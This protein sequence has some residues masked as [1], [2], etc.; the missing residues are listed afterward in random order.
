MALR[1][2]EAKDVTRKK[3]LVRVDFNVPIKDGMVM[4]DTRI[5]AHLETLRFLK[6][7]GSFITL[8]SHLGRPKEEGILSF[9]SSPWQ[10]T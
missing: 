1:I 6:E 7:N 8:I 4:D 9:H 2:P 10:S 3:V 5:K